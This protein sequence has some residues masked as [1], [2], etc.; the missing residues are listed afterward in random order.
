MRCFCLAVHWYNPLVWLAVTLSRR[1]SEL[2]CDEGTIKHLGEASLLE[3]GQTI[4]G[5]TCEKRKTMDLLCCSTT[6]TDGKKGIRER[7]TL[8]ARKPKVLMSAL[9]AIVLVAAVAAGCTFTG[10]KSENA[11]ALKA[12]ESWPFGA[13]VTLDSMPLPIHRF[14]A[15][16]INDT[17]KKYMGITLNDLSGVGTDELIYLKAYDAYYNFTS[18]AGFSSFVCSSGEKQGDIIRLYSE[19]AILTQSFD[20]P[21]R[22]VPKYAFWHYRTNRQIR[23]IPTSP[24]ISRF[25]LLLSRQHSQRGLSW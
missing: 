11:E 1:D 24:V 23:Y 3:Y 15:K 5:L 4:I 12:A 7:I 8:I 19:H 18:D 14:T 9:V 25:T 13:A 10:A 22:H 2:A 17:L 20:F 16:T 21:P 6:M